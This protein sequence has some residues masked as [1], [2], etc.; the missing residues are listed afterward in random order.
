[1]IRGW[2]YDLAV[3]RG[4]LE[5]VLASVPGSRVP[6]NL[7]KCAHDSTQAR[8]R[9]QPFLVGRQIHFDLG[10][11]GLAGKS[12]IHRDGLVQGAKPPGPLCDGYASSLQPGHPCPRH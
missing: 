12:V 3:D 8:W 7:P 6:E 4:H 1:M 10:H 2:F 11:D 9:N 5:T